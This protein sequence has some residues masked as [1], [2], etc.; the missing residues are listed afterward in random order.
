PLVGRAPGRAARARRRRGG[1]RAAR[2]R[3]RRLAAGARRARQHVLADGALHPRA[4]GAPGGAA[5]LRVAGL[6]ARPRRRGR[7]ARLTSVRL[8]TWNIHK[9]IG[10]VDRRYSPGRVTEVLKHYDADVVL[11]Q[12]VDDGVP[13]SGN[14]RQVDLIADVLDYKHRAFGGNVRLKVGCY[15]NATLSRFPIV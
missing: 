10:G 1:A 4:A 7:A 6:R 14:D 2:R 9:G 15:G 12:E 8:L 3:D 11:L 5:S 13:R